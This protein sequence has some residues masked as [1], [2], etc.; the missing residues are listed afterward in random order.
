MQTL[1]AGG[2]RVCVTHNSVVVVSLELLSE[3]A[4]ASVF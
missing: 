1:S 3:S 2:G 4:F